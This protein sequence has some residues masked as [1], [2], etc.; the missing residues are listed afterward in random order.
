MEREDKLSLEI[1][2]FNHKQKFNQKDLKPP[3]LPPYLTD[4]ENNPLKNIPVQ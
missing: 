3:S 1:E 2:E 4:L